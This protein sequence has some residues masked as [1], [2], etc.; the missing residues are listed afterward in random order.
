M[1]AQ[2]SRDQATALAGKARAQFASEIATAQ[3]TYQDA[4]GR[5]KRYGSDIAPRS[6][7]L[8]STMSY[9]YQ[10]GGASLLDLLSAERSDNDVRLAGAQAAADT[11][12]SIANLKAAFTPSDEKMITHEN[13]K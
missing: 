7:Q 8:R 5:W 9:A 3:V 11:A 13:A 6:E 10:K 2:A 4:F 1:A 12:L